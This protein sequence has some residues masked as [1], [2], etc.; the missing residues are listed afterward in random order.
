MKQAGIG[1]AVMYLYKHPKE[2]KENKEI[3]S[4][5]REEREQRDLEQC[6]KKRRTSDATDG[7]EGSSQDISRAMSGD[8]K[9]LRPGDPGW[10][11]RARVPMP[12]NKDYVVR[13]KWKVD[14][15]ISKVGTLNAW[16]AMKSF[17]IQ[18][19]EQLLPRTRPQLDQGRAR[20]RHLGLVLAHVNRQDLVLAHEELQLLQLDQD[21]VLAKLQGLDLAQA[22]DEAQH[23]LLG[24]EAPSH[25]AGQ[26]LARENR[27]ARDHAPGHV[28]GLGPALV[29]VPEKHQGRQEGPGRA[30]E[31]VPSHQDHR[32]AS[33]GG[34][35]LVQSQ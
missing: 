31:M 13:P 5:S 20:T 16:T 26:S 24:H 27:P 23:H 18:S 28:Q 3:A 33:V 14:T 22:H 25:E 15:D 32:V 19:F 10:V 17:F 12:S 4:M 7:G 30:P 2:T 34:L 8:A 6:P 9:S 35:A 1:K 21:Q 11:G 29:R